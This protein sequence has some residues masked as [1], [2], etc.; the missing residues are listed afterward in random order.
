MSI[1]VITAQQRSAWQ[2]KCNVSLAWWQ[3]VWILPARVSN[4]QHEESKFSET[5]ERKEGSYTCV[6]GLPWWFSRKESI[7]LQCRRWEMWVWSMAGED[8]LEEEVAT[9]FSI[10]AW[11]IPRAEEPDRLQSKGFK[12]SDMTEQL[13]RSPFLALPTS[14]SNSKEGSFKDFWKWTRDQ[15]SSG[16]YKWL[17]NKICLTP[18]AN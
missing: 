6:Y 7:C 10:L 4:A 15:T 3:K 13:T 8:P 12:E 16:E 9:H 18:Q 17:I 2:G 11:K 1:S 5:W 14:T